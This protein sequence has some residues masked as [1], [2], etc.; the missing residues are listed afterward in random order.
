[1]DVLIR[2][3][4]YIGF[5]FFMEVTFVAISKIVDGKIKGRD[6]YLEGHTYLWMAPIYGFLLLFVFEPVH[7]LT[8]NIHPLFRFVIWSITFTFF[9]ALSGWLYDMKLGFC[10][11]DYSKSKFKMFK[12]GYT[13]WNLV[14]Q[15]GIAGL[16]IEGYSHMLIRNSGSMWNDYI[17]YITKFWGSF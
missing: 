11:W 8:I 10:P 15:W 1:V 9:E 2:F 13:K 12:R 5:G 14:P 17:S 7:A 4:S 16:F 6:I 3:F